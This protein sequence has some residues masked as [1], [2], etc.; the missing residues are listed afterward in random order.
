MR[1]FA[2]LAV[3]L[4]AVGEVEYGSGTGGTPGVDRGGVAGVVCVADFAAERGI[5]AQSERIFAR[6]GGEV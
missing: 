3:L 4:A 6:G 5:F 2:A 1:E